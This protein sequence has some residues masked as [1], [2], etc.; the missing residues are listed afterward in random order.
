MAISFDGSENYT[1]GSV[2]TFDSR[3]ILNLVTDIAQGLN[4]SIPFTFESYDRHLI[5]EF[6]SQSVL[7]N[8]KSSVKT[9]NAEITYDGQTYLIKSQNCTEHFDSVPPVWTYD[10]VLYRDG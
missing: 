9:G 7:D 2:V 4:G 8:F 10:I 3:E 5:V 1:T 6:R